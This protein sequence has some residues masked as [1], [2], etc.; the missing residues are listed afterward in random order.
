MT[1]R[2]TLETFELG[3]AG[4]DRPH[5]WCRQKTSRRPR[6]QGYDDGYKRAGTTPSARR[7]RM[8]SASGRNSPAISAISGFNLRGGPGARADIP[9]GPASGTH[10]HVFLPGLNGRRD[11]PRGFLEALATSPAT[12]AGAP[13]ADPRRA[14]RG[15]QVEELSH[16]R[17]DIARA[18][19]RASR[20]SPK[21]RPGSS[22]AQKERQVRS[23]GAETSRPGARGDPRPRRRHRK[24]TR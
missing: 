14:R 6:L 11:R 24:D 23:R 2:V 10:R 7:R 21:G 12:L 18:G 22:S 1:R 13:C 5:P 3:C 19:R 15:R 8:G 20:L 16:G 4:T 9:R 17:D